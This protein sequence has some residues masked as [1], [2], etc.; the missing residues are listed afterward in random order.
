MAT[1]RQ[2]QERLRRAVREAVRKCLAE[3]D[4]PEAQEGESRF[5]TIEALAL[6]AGDAV[7][8]D[9]DY[10]YS[11]T[12]LKKVVYAGTQARS[13][14]QGVSVLV[15]GG[16]LGTRGVLGAGLP[17]FRR[18]KGDKPWKAWETTQ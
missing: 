10:D 8:L 5:T 6:A 1:T 16:K 3:G 9:V 14:P 17:I 13:F 2:F 7:S 12:V 4:L 11:P 15:V 18:I